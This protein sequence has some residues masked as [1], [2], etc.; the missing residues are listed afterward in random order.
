[1]LRSEYLPIKRA[2]IFFQK[3][4]AYILYIVVRRFVCCLCAI[5]FVFFVL[6]SCL[7]GSNC[8]TNF[9]LEHIQS[10]TLE[11]FDVADLDAWLFRRLEYSQ[12]YRLMYFVN[13]CYYGCHEFVRRFIIFFCSEFLL[14]QWCTQ[15]IWMN[16]YHILLVQKK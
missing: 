8:R 4:R 12:I 11:S 13:L 2:Y 9:V 15:S 3:R 16:E 6:F 5:L 7:F 10:T 14:Y 1:M